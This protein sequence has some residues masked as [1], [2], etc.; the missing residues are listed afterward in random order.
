M[1]KPKSAPVGT[2]ARRSKHAII[3]E[4]PDYTELF[5][6]APPMN[7]KQRRAQAKSPTPTQSAQDQG[8]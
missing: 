1:S 7:R 6:A 3:T 4:N 2:R 8:H 5:S